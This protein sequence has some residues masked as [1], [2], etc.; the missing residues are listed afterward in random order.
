[1]RPISNGM[2][3]IPS[4][5]FFDEQPVKDLIPK[6]EILKN[7]G[8]AIV[9]LD[10]S[11][12][13]FTK[14]SP[15][16]GPEF[17]TSTLGGM[18]T[19]ELHL[20][21]EDVAVSLEKWSALKNI[22]RIVVHP[23]SEFNVGDLREFCSRAG[24]ELAWSLQIGGDLGNFVDMIEV[25]NAT[26]AEL[27]AVPLGFSGGEFDPSV[28]ERVKFLKQIHPDLGIFIDGGVNDKTAAT[29]KE[30]GASGVVS[31]SYLW[32]SSDV[33]AAYDTLRTI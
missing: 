24:A 20:M 5:N 26:M 6:L 8:V 12:G 1:M 29:M 3:V 31:G 23:E 28:L 9:H 2:E 13:K 21:V 30:S 18:F 32:Q 11:D 33:G 22:E 16:P 10:I 15:G 14:A 27:V 25:T 19:F 17:F 4:I 7:R